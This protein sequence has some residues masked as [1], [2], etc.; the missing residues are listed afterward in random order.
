MKHLI[1][2]LL[3]VITT[4]GWAQTA[5]VPKEK[6]P[7]FILGQVKI[8]EA[9]FVL[10][11]QK[12]C[13]LDLCNPR[14]CVYVSHENV[15]LQGDQVLPG[16]PSEGRTRVSPEPQYILTA[17]TCEYVYEKDLDKQ[18]VQDLN[19]RLEYR[20]SKGV[21]RVAARGIEIPK[22]ATQ[23]GNDQ[24]A[25][26]SLLQKIE[27]LLLEHF[28]WIL[29]VALS[30]LVL[31]VGLWA[32]RRVGRDTKEDELRFLA[33]KR[34]LESDSVQNSEQEGAGMPP[35]DAEARR[36]QERIT[37]LTRSHDQ[38]PQLLQ[39]L[40]HLWLEEGELS[41]VASSLL[42]LA[43]AKESPLGTETQISL[44]G[45][46]LS[47]FMRSFVPVQ[48]EQSEVLRELEQ[49]QALK[50]HF[51]H[52]M[53]L[54]VRRLFQ[55]HDVESLMTLGREHGFESMRALLALAPGL[56]IRELVDA[57]APAEILSL[58]QS[59]WISNRVLTRELERWSAVGAGSQASMLPGPER[60][61]VSQECDA[62]WV[63]GF[64]L[65]NLRVDQ[66]QEVEELPRKPWTRFLFYPELLNKL[67]E[68]Q[69]RD[70]LLSV[71]GN[72]L[73][74]WYASLVG[75]QQ[76]SIWKILPDAYRTQI[77]ASSPARVDMGK[78]MATVKTFGRETAR[79]VE[80]GA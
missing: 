6:I 17:A 11:L 55:D 14:G 65:S 22:S 67:S 41:K 74:H 69:A 29:A 37:K 10:A 60:K 25:P 40:L 34:E 64:L 33:Y 51:D 53:T 7:D 59:F 48:V 63:V 73:L 50:A 19:R 45:L 80:E 62:S 47:E 79:L 72:H 27:S 18:M 5:R 15:S 70:I 12:D 38:N 54:H 32:W 42:L 2:I 21:L 30:I 57:L 78:V 3:L 4:E 23:H 43:E 68:S 52:R 61:G 20:L 16:L 35:E 66:R 46:K 71:D 76:R 58:A 28:P 24:A 56:K 77:R 44:Q 39:A 31:T 26:L 1:G 49:E 36:L 13:G 75:N 8:I 9:D